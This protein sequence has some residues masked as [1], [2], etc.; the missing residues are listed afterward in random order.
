MGKF[1]EKIKDVFT[2]KF[3]YKP[4]KTKEP[5]P[6]ATQPQGEKQEEKPKEQK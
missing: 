5:Q 2:G 1:V 4:K 3:V 6:S